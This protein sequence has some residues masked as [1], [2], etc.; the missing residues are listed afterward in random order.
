M[1]DETSGLESS[2]FQFSAVSECPDSDDRVP[3]C[4]FP[5]RLH[6]IHHESARE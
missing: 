4:E 2:Y 1:P 5:D 3:H 6:R